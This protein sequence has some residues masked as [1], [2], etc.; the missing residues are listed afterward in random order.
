MI[1]LWGKNLASKP[2]LTLGFS[3]SFPKPTTFFLKLSAQ[4]VFQVFVDGKLVAFGPNRTALG[5]ARLSELQLKGQYLVIKVHSHLINSYAYI[6]QSPFFAAEIKTDDG[7]LYNSHDFLCYLLDDRVQ[8]VSRYSYQRG[9][10]EA[11][12]LNDNPRRFLL[13]SSIY[14]LVE[15]EN[16]KLPRLIPSHTPNPKMD[17]HFPHL[18]E[19]GMI[20]VS[21][22]PAP[23]WKPNFITLVG[24]KLEGFKEAHFEECPLNEVKDF[25]RSQK[26]HHHPLHY[27]IFDFQRAM[28]GFFK[29]KV[30][31]LTPGPIYAIFDEILTEGDVDY[32]RNNTN[33]VIKWHPLFKGEA[34]LLTM[35]PYTARY[36]KIILPHDAR[37]QVSIVDFE[38]D[39]V[40]RLQFASSDP[41][42]NLIFN[43]AKNTLAQNAVDILMDCP[44]RER[45]GWLSD[46]YF[47]S[48]AE[49]YFTGANRVEEAFLEN[50]RL[51][52]ETTLPKGM[53][54]MVY[55]SD[56]YDQVF[57]PNWSLWYI[58]EVGKYHLLYKK[59]LDAKTKSIIKSLLAYFAK[60]ENEDGLLENLESWVFVEWSAANDYEHVRGVNIPTNALYA[61]ALE[62]A[63]CL[64]DQIK[65]S[66]KANR[67]KD[68]I[69]RYAYNGFYFVDNL[70]RNDNNILEQTNH[71]TEVCQYYLFWLETITRED[72]P[73]LY[74][75]LM[76]ELGPYRLKKHEDIAPPNMMYG[77]YMRLDLL[78]R[79]G[80]QHELLKECKH[81]F[82]SMAAQTGTLWENNL[83]TASCNHGFASYSIRWLIYGLSGYDHLRPDSLHDLK[84]NG[85]NERII[86]PLSDHQTL[87]LTVTHEGVK[88]N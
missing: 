71:L 7:K 35:E 48:T 3:F 23:L 54:P 26:S 32:K 64:L 40:N 84:A 60:F 42:L 17:E 22:L 82:L 36:I 19:S 50:Y 52:K 29:L 21:L 85:R 59:E 51:L 45:A 27:R 41:D 63:S 14:P 47:S 79:A 4:T 44:S 77:I 11:Y 39:D 15:T 46:S 49:Y 2:N 67:I 78:L 58:L 72:Y 76:T 1:A 31:L 38:N 43:A 24:E 75:H 70:V 66:K 88:V 28:T 56:D 57:I 30:K 8:K 6:K 34:E 25:H 69:R 83:P 62:V 65:P 18:L 16:A 55:P 37:I 80:N 74:D 81:Y 68:Y 5:Y 61:R 12:R 53:I 9:F 86:L 20:E 10:S 33:N 13:G 73:V 87:S